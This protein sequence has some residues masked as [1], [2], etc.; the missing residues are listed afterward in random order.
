LPYD[1]KIQEAR[2]LVDFKNDEYIPPRKPQGI[3]DL[4]YKAL[5]T[6]INF[7]RKIFKI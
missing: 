4:L 2:G 5:N 1:I 7:V 6:W 3:L